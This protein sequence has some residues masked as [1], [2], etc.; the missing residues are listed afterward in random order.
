VLE[1]VD[2][3][4]FGDAVRQRIGI[5]VDVEVVS[6]RT[7]ERSE[8]K[9][10]RV[11]DLRG[12][13]GDGPSRRAAVPQLAVARASKPGGPSTETITRCVPVRLSP[14]RFSPTLT[15]AVPVSSDV[16]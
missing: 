10:K 2:P 12:A 4:E 16:A 8:G 11:R 13:V 14:T 5:S 6:P 3:V 15:V 9:A 7:I 1:A